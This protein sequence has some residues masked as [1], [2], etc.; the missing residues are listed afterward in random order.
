MPEHV[1]PGFSVMEIRELMP[2]P[3]VHVK[4]VVCDAKLIAPRQAGFPAWISYLAPLLEG[5]AVG[6][7]P[8]PK[9][10]RKPA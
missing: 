6:D 8:K 3:V 7:D 4:S 5:K 10:S 2:I 9:N 1:H